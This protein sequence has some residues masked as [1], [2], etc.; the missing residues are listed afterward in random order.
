VGLLNPFG[1]KL[2]AAIPIPDGWSDD[3]HGEQGQQED[4]DQG[5]AGQRAG[6]AMIAHQDRPQTKLL[7][8]QV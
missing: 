3:G 7:M 5:K 4:E 6:I 1:R 2:K 8:N